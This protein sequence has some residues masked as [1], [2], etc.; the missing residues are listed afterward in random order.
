MELS[1]L[2]PIVIIGVTLFLIL[3]L[4]VFHIVRVSTRVGLKQNKR[5]VVHVCCG[6]YTGS[7]KYKTRV[8]E[9]DR[10]EVEEEL[11]TL[12]K[13]RVE[14]AEAARAKRKPEREISFDQLSAADSL[15]GEQTA[16]IVSP[17]D[18]SPISIPVKRAPPEKF[19]TKASSPPKPSPPNKP[20]SPSG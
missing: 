7:Q 3:L 19:P 10:E 1:Q 9:A 15:V 11:R 5:V 4:G 18:T 14:K 2:L 16:V 8:A 13:E 17:P 6:G 20:S 12:A